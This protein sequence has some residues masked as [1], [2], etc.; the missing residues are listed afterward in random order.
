MKPVSV[1]CGENMAKNWNIPFYIV[2]AIKDGQRGAV[3]S[4]FA[5]DGQ[6]TNQS[7][8]SDVFQEL[9]YRIIENYQE[10][11]LLKSY[12][13]IPSSKD[14]PHRNRDEEYNICCIN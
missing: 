9:V 3:W 5:P 2:S 1:V 6:N 7:T 13:V 14:E 10:K 11:E 4:I 12:I 8:I